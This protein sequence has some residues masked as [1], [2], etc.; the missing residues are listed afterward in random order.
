MI[1]LFPRFTYLFQM[2]KYFKCPHIKPKFDYNSRFPIPYTQYPR[3]S[4]RKQH[5]PSIR[6]NFIVQKPRR[7]SSWHLCMT[8]RKSSGNKL[9][10]K[11]DSLNKPNSRGNQQPCH[12]GRT[13]QRS[14]KS[15]SILF[16]KSNG[17]SKIKCLITI[18][19]NCI[20]TIL[21]KT[22]QNTTVTNP[23]KP[24]ILPEILYNKISDVNKGK[25]IP[26]HTLNIDKIT[27]IYSI[28]NLDTKIIP[29]SGIF[30]VT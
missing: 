17:P 28:Q 24:L 11:Q 30:P 5:L 27:R 3:V 14:K 20:V 19:D 2:N 29:P 1:K 8:Q 18:S 13:A 26:L 9:S 15:S 4:L 7:N 12:H 6:P 23:R 22:F 16:Y 21:G 10:K 25:P